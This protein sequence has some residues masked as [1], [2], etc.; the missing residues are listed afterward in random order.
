[1]SRLSES[2]EQISFARRYTLERIE[3]VPLTEWFT[4]PPGGVSHIAWQVGHTAMAEYRL[5]LERLRVRTPADESLIPDNFLKVFGRESL[6]A[7][8]T[9]YTAEEIRDVHARVHARVMEELPTYADADLDLA[10]LK[11]HPLFST[12]LAGLRYAPLHEMIHC[13]QLA[14]IRRMLGQPPLW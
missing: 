1:M 11:P 14:M 8:V 5:C 2:L 13:G 6:P 10:P 4:V 7:S 12:R 9:G 3:T